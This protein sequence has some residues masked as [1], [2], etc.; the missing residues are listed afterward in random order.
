MAERAVDRRAIAIGLLLL[1]GWK[2]PV[3]ILLDAG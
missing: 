1:I 2:R 3:S